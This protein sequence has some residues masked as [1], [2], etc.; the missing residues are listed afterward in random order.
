MGFSTYIWLPNG[1]KYRLYQVPDEPRSETLQRVILDKWEDYCHANWLSSNHEDMNCPEKKVKRMLESC[2]MFL[3]RGEESDNMLTD[4]RKMRINKF[5]I[6][7]SACPPH[8][9]AMIPRPKDQNGALESEMFHDMMDRLGERYDR[10]LEKLHARRPLKRKRQ[11][12]RGD[13]AIK[14]KE[15]YPNHRFVLA[16]VDTENYFQVCGHTFHIRADVPAYQGETLKDGD[17]YYAMDRIV[18]GVP[19]DSA[20]KLVFFD[21]EWRAL[22]EAG[23]GST[24]VKMMEDTHAGIYQS[25][26]QADESGCDDGSRSRADE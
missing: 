23:D 16:A 21:M 10:N 25:K 22:D 3:L 11:E 14:M 9:Q 8:I 7:L 12:T 15:R 19:R 18:V 17:I 4:Y 24:V 5:E 26:D 1:I 6:P 2:A 13:R 20:D